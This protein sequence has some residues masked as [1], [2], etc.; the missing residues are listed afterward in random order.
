MDE[1][2]EIV[3]RVSGSS[4][5]TFDLEDYFQAGDRIQFDLKDLLFHGLIVKEKD[6]RDYIKTHPWSQYQ[7]KLVAIH[8][9][10]DAIVPTWAYMLLTIALE[11]FA[12][13]IV[14]GNL[15]N[16]EEQ[17]YKDELA[18]VNWAVYQDAKVVVKGCSKVDVP[19]SAYV[20]VVEKLRPFASSLMYGE[21]CSTVPLY[22]RPKQ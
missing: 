17:L 6:F 18:K 13:K 20:E 14:F 9:S 11:P 5:V 8:C 16:L 1:R 21:P 10:A 12:R 15:Q 19:L 22:K 2:K 7:D 4:L 3:N